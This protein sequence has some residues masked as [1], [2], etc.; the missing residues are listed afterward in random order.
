MKIYHYFITLFLLIC[1]SSLL[2]DDD[3]RVWISIAADAVD[4]VEK[5]QPQSIDIA[6]LSSD[7]NVKN[8]A[9]NV[10]IVSVPESQIDGLSE[11]MHDTFNRC[12]GYF[13]HQSLDDALTF[14]KKA[15]LL[16]SNKIF[17]YSINN[18]NTVASLLSQ[19]SPTNLESTIASLSSYYNR[20]YQ[21]QSGLDSAASILDNWQTIAGNRSDIS[22]E[23][24][25]HANWIQPS[26]TVTISG[27]DLSDEIVVVGGHLDSI[28]SRSNANG[29]APG[30]DDNASG[31]AVITELLSMI[32]GSDYRPARTLMLMGYAAEE[33]GLRGSKDIARSYYTE[34]RSVVGVAQFDMTGFKGSSD[35]DIVFITD[36]TNQQQTEFMEDLLDNYFPDV[37]YGH[38]TCGYACSDHAAWTNYGFPASFP[39]E[40]FF[41]DSNPSIHTASDTAVKVDHDHVMTFTRLA[42]AYVAELAKGGIGV[43]EPAAV[44]GLSSSEVIVD[45]G[46]ETNLTVERTGD[47]N[48]VISV[49]FTT[50]DNTALAE[51]DYTAVS[52][53]LSWHAQ[54]TV[55]KTIT[56]STNVVS[57]DKSFSLELSNAQGNAI[58]TAESSA[59][60]T[61]NS[62]SPAPTSGGNSGGG[63]IQPLLLLILLLLSKANLWVRGAFL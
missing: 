2:A 18:S 34:N 26:V 10:V 38:D 39:F 43:N 51:S 48:S 31:I 23:Y 50:V 1:S 12:S 14:N 5:Q 9:Q 25:Q 49:D 11:L 61:I 44:I 33:V 60:I 24:Y 13:F 32:V 41:N 57:T 63:L 40:S 8:S 53:T 35:R 17:G 19:L 21:S 47:I 29:E 56:I 3:K 16:K 36:Y 58:L 46:D 15:G 37:S 59:L 27:T 22:V 20:Y 7:T 30:A 28:N 45:G 6:R 62:N 4:F 54:E 55:A 42:A 52:G